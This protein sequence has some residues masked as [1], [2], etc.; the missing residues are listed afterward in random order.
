MAAE[1][2]T[3][4]FCR[5]LAGAWIDW[6][7]G[8]KVQ[9]SDSVVCKG[10]IYRVQAEPDGTVYT[11]NTEPSHE[12]GSAVLDGIDWGVV[13]SDVTYTAGVRNVVFRDIFLEKARIGFSIHFDNDRYS[14]SYYP[15][16]TI[17]IQEQLR[18]DDIRVIRDQPTDL[19]SI[20]TPVD[21]V[22][23]SGSSIKNNPIRFRGNGAMPDYLKTRINLLG[24]VFRHGGPMDLVT[25]DVEGKEILL[26]TSASIQISDEFV[27]RVVP[28]KGRIVTESDLSGLEGL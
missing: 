26:K 24:C 3:G 7:P 2:T 21:V 4:Y 23:L 19:L 9:Q 14:R 20:G 10:R 6:S 11:S 5:I 16:A 18:F 1:E 25:N 28:G 8:I 15:G 22:T 27:P 17:P 13:Q 12:S